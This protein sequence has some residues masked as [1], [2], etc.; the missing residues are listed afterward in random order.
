MFYVSIKVTARIYYE[1]KP[2]LLLTMYGEIIVGKTVFYRRI[3]YR[4][5]FG[6]V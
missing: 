6:C 2:V 1:Y 4:Y 5:E 3:K